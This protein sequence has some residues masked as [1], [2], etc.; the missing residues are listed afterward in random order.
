MD[1]DLNVESIELST[2]EQFMVFLGL[3]SPS[4]RF[5]GGVTLTTGVI[6]ALKPSISFDASGN[7]RA[8]SVTSSSSNSTLVP[9][10]LPGVMVGGALATL[11]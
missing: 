6:L 5:L 7:A 4:L 10:W 8:W 9:W 11:L 1:T 2:L 3:E